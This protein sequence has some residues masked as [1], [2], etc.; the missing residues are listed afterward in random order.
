[1]QAN[2]TDVVNEMIQDGIYDYDFDYLEENDVTDMLDCRMETADEDLEKKLDIIREY[3]ENEKTNLSG[4]IQ[5]LGRT[6]RA[7]INNIR[8]ERG[9]RFYEVI[10]IVALSHGFYFALTHWVF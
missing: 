8:V 1:M 4:R 5:E 7:D 10:G 6:L 3:F 2:L 9:L